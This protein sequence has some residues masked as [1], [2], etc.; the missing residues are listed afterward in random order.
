MSDT[1]ASFGFQDV[2]PGDKPGLVRGVFDRV[3]L[4]L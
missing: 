4:A 3:A 2:E 1:R